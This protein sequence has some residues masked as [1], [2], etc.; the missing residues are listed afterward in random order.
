M[1]QALIKRQ[2]IKLSNDVSNI[3]CVK[4]NLAENLKKICFLY[5]VWAAI[6]HLIICFDQ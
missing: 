2:I 1:Y 5:I 6:S 4:E 3:K